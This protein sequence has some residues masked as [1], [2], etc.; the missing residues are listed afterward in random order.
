MSIK[1]NLNGASLSVDI[2]PET[3]LLWAIRDAVGLKGTKFG[4][5]MGICGTCTV[6]IDGTAV[7][8]CAIAV[9]DA[10]GA[11]ITTIEGLGDEADPHPLQQAWIDEQVPQCGY[12]QP[13]MIMAAFA[14]LKD[15]PNPTDDDLR[16]QITN[17]CRC[18]TYGR[19]FKAIRRVADMRADV[20]E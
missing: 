17:V 5:G 4:C 8:S 7:R 16:A 18:G 11:Q 20:P 9:S 3:P 12:C 10:Q 13:G 6:D 19:I 14:M 2:A 15:N 1:L